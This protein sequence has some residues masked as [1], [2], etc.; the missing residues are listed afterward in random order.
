MLSG[1]NSPNTLGTPSRSSAPA[2]GLAIATWALEVNRSQGL[3]DAPGDSRWR[4]YGWRESPFFFLLSR[5]ITNQLVQ[6]VHLRIVSA[7]GFQDSSNQCICASFQLRS[8][9]YGSIHGSIHGPGCID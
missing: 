8:A 1:P 7:D 2:M 4:V 6:P 5:E 3:R 9:V